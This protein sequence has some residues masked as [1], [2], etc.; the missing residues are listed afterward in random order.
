MKL[1]ILNAITFHP[2][3]ALIVQGHAINANSSTENIQLMVEGQELHMPDLIRK[4]V[5]SL[6][7]KWDGGIT[8]SLQ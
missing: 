4:P 5:D 8:K 1:E 6:G 3:P 7:R 2:S